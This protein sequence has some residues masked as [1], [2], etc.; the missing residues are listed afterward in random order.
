MI[1]RTFQN[2]MTVTTVGINGTRQLLDNGTVIDTWEKADAN[3]SM[4]RLAEAM[5]RGK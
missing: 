3:T 5:I 1:T 2:G 4:R